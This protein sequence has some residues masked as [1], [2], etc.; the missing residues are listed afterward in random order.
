VIAVDS[1]VL[2]DMLTDD[3]RFAAASSKAIE[4]ALGAGGVVV[5]DAVVAEVQTLLDT[6]ETA[7]DVLNEYGIHYLPT[8]EQA[9]VRAG[10]MQ[11]RFRDRGGRRERVV[12]DF[13]IGAHAMMQC[14]ALITRDAAFYRDYFKGLRVIV[15]KA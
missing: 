13:L 5:C 1:T 2:L 4:Q 12:A 14:D 6:S 10:Y 3:P 9:A 7:M 11:R 8:T 15:P